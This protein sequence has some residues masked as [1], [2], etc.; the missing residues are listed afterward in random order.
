[1]YLIKEKKEK[2]KKK[3]N[4]MYIYVN[5][6][7]NNIMFYITFNIDPLCCLYIKNGQ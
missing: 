5:Y 1:M 2:M 4:E 3:Q 6:L 7:F